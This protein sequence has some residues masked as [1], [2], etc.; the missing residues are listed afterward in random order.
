MQGWLLST[1]VCISPGCPHQ[2]ASRTLYSLKRKRNR[3]RQ[4][5]LARLFT[6][7]R[8]PMEQFVRLACSDFREKPIKNY[9]TNLHRTT[10]GKGLDA[11]AYNR[12]GIRPATY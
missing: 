1:M 5:S 6:K 2:E 4:G 10:P 7:R 12:L 9:V 8:R 3:G 11:L